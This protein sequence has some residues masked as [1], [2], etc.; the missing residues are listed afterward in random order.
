MS[1]LTQPERDELARWLKQAG[2][3]SH[4]C[5]HC[6][7]LHLEGVLEEQGVLETRLFRESEG[8]LLTVELELRPA[9]AFHVLAEAPRLNMA[10]PTLKIFPDIGDEAPPRLVFCNLLL[11]GAGISFDQF[12]NFLDRTLEA[13]AGLLDELLRQGICGWPDEE[14]EEVPAHPP[15]H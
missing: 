7:G 1:T 13:A 2:I 5:D 8:L 11:T 4:L 15:L 6:A 9:A 12:R 14:G 10:W 3:P